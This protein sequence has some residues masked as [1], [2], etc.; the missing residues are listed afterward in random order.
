VSRR[1]VYLDSSA[2]VKVIVEEPGSVELRRWLADRP[3]RAS[4]ALART[5]VVRAV[6][7]MGPEVAA[8]ARRAI[9]DL[10]LIAVDD[11]L[12]DAA[13]TVEPDVLRSLDA[14]HLAAARSLGD[15]LLAI[16]TYDDRM[17][18]GARLLGL[19]TVRPA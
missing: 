1:T 18:E 7:R 5:E 19:P 8:K 17:T 14:I 13:A 2:I 10:S 6:R 4:S 15:D 12:L 11:A 3:H 9:A 16:V